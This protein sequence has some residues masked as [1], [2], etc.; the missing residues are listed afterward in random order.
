LL[1]LK[2][3]NLQRQ[4]TQELAIQREKNPQFV[5]GVKHKATAKDIDAAEF[6]SRL[7]GSFWQFKLRALSGKPASIIKIACWK[8]I[9]ICIFANPCCIII[10]NGTARDA[11]ITPKEREND[12]IFRF[13]I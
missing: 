9:R 11:N 13:Y 4:L 12:R 5:F 1:I 8:G 10:R 2:S 7:N 3:Q 6:K